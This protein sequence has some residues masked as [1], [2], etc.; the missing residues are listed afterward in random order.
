MASLGSVSI[1]MPEHP[2][3]LSIKELCQRL[4]N[5]EKIYKFIAEHPQAGIYLRF[6]ELRALCMSYFENKVLQCG[7]T[8]KSHIKLVA[9]GKHHPRW[10]DD[11]YSDLDQV[12]VPLMESLLRYGSLFVLSDKSSSSA[13]IL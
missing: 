11:G 6:S 4:F 1:Q 2:A 12:I 8:A 5:G 9:D 7:E 10:N 13:N 3:P